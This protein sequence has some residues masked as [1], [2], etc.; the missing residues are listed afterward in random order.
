MSYRNNFASCFHS[1]GFCCAS[2]GARG[3]EGDQREGVYRKSERR[4][5]SVPGRKRGVPCVDESALENKNNNIKKV[6]K[7]YDLHQGV[8]EVKQSHFIEFRVS[9]L[10]FRHKHNRLSLMCS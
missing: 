3:E 2:W 6:K 4:S 7:W 1:A 8:Q 9:G 5:K 10:D